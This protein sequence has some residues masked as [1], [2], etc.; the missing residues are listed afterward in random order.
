[1][2][3][4]GGLSESL[5]FGLKVN[6]TIISGRLACFS[7]AWKWSLFTGVLRPAQP[8]IDNAAAVLI[9]APLLHLQALENA[10]FTEL[11]Q[12]LSAALESDRSSR[13][14]EMR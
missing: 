6:I 11:L 12:Q 8:G 14:D 2:Q 7:P 13:R 4:G 9:L 1:M 3:G 10:S 5:R